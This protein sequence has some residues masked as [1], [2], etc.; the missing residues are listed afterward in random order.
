MNRSFADELVAGMKRSLQRRYAAQGVVPLDI[1]LR[2]E[3][4]RLVE[5][6]RAEG[7]RSAR[8]PEATP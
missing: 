4:L 2:L 8:Q 5:I 7:A 1:K 3:R 6:I